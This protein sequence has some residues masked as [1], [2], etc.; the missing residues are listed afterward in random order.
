MITGIFMMKSRMMKCDAAQR[1]WTKRITRL[2]LGGA[3]GLIALTGIAPGVAL[4]QDSDKGLFSTMLKSLGL[5]GEDQIEY[6]ERPPLV[7]PPTRALPPPQSSAG[8]RDP[9]W[10]VQSAEPRKRGDP[11]RDLDRIAIPQRP[12]ES[13][14]AGAGAPVPLAG[15][16]DTTAAIPPSQPATPGGLFGN[17]FN[18]GDRQTGGTVTSARP[19]KSLTQPPPDY[20]SPSPGQPY[21]TTPPADSAKST[22]PETPPGNAGL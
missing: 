16:A 4:A 20:Q 10:P 7:V 15:G 12:G 8:V 9:N 18:S 13:S 22:K 1:V 19:R 5:A 2:A 11:I 6:R 17:L 14:G 3:L 21:G